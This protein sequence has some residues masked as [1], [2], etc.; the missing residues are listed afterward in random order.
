MG[1][2]VSCSCNNQF[3]IEKA[4]S[5]NNN[6]YIIDPSYTNLL[7][8]QDLLY[9]HTSYSNNSFTKVCIIYSSKLEQFLNTASFFLIYPEP[10]APDCHYYYNTIHICNYLQQTKYTLIIMQSDLKSII[11]SKQM[12]NAFK[13]VNL[14]LMSNN[15]V[16]IKEQIIN[17]L[18]FMINKSYILVGIIDKGSNNYIMIFKHSEVKYPNYEIDIYESHYKTL[19]QK[20]IENIFDKN[21]YNKDKSVDKRLV[22]LMK[23]VSETKSGTTFFFIFEIESHK[24]DDLNSTMNSNSNDNKENKLNIQSFVRGQYPTEQ[25][26]KDVSEICN[27]KGII[28]SSLSTIDSLYAIF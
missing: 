11:S 19:T 22:C 4:H 24:N 5:Y 16:L 21:A 13:T 27:E 17:D 26:V 18:I 3:D 8:N 23:N 7:S 28:E 15:S 10:K 14:N 20:E 1:L 9:I 25:Y 6:N 2:T 12:K